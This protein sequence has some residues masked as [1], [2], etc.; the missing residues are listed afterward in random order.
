MANQFANPANPQYHRETT[1]AEIL[2]DFAGKRL[3]YFVSGYGTGGTISGVGE[4][5]KAARKDLQVIVYEPT[6]AQLLDG[7]D[8]KPHKIQGVVPDFIAET[9]NEQIYDHRVAVSDE[10]ARDTSLALAAQEGITAGI[11]AGAAFNAALQFAQKAPEGSVFLVSL[12]DGS[13]RYLSTFLF[14]SINDGSDDNL[15]P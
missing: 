12:P 10:E 5:L 4:V 2:R 6:N 8:W 14:E 3:D 7:K 9:M 15:L 1:A 11:S 13:E